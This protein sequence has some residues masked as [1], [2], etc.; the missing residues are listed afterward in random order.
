MAVQV[1][2]SV[3]VCTFGLEILNPLFHSFLKVM[4]A[5]GKE[6]RDM[7]TFCFFSCSSCASVAQ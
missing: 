4:A 1:M 5:M 2:S 7:I 6:Q 3:M